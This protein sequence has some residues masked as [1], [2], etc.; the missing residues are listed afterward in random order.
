M[1]I[2]ILL[3]EKVTA[4]DFVGPYEVLSRIPNTEVCFTGV[5]KRLYADSGLLK[6]SADYSLKDVTQTDIL[7][8][9]GGFGVDALLHD[10]AVI[11]W[12]KQI[13]KTSQ[14]TVSV[15][16]GSLLLAEAGILNGK[17]C[18][19]HWNRKDQLKKY[20]VE[21]VD[22]RYV[23]DGKYITSAGVSA[24]IDMAL[25]LAGKIIGDKGAMMIQR[26]IE[27]NPMPPYSYESIINQS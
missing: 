8:I 20:D 27:Y 16:S 11:S 23:Q 3:Y 6:F 22:E 25:F 10:E 26:G 15:C 18:T 7:L 14:W 13:D 19:T 21:I 17:K 24:G 5:E 2:A 1:K 12:V 9:P 4:L